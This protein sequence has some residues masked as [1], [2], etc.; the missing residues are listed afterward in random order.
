MTAE[1]II[2]E[3][4]NNLQEIM[5]SASSEVEKLHIKLGEVNKILDVINNLNESILN[6]NIS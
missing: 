6:N 1:Q 3:R 5:D 4:I 2:N